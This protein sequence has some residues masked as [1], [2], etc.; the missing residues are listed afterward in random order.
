MFFIIILFFRHDFSHGYTIFYFDL[1]NCVDDGDV[2]FG[3]SLRS[4]NLQIQA[5]FD[6]PTAETCNM[7]LY[8]NFPGL[9]KVDQARN[10][11]L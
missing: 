9:I 2:N 4:G 1:T 11:L 5:Y 10:V 6:A 3:S 7:I 8:A